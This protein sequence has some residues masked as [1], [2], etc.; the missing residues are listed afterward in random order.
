MVLLTFIFHGTTKHAYGEFT[1]GNTCSTIT[2]VLIDSA[3]KTNNIIT[4]RF[5]NIHVSL[6]YLL[7]SVLNLAL[8][9][10]RSKFFG[11]F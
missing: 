1:S 7:V 5:S 3:Y 6:R 9:N 11:Y 2:N 8:D 4:N 10:K